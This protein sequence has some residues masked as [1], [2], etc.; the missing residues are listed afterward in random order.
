M[1]AVLETFRS[2]PQVV[3]DVGDGFAGARAAPGTGRVRPRSAVRVRA[4]GRTTAPI[5]AFDPPWRL[6]TTATPGGVLAWFG[7]VRRDGT[8]DAFDPGL[9]RIGVLGP[10]TYDIEI[11][12]ATYQSVELQVSIPAAG[13]PPSVLAVE[14]EAG[15]AYPFRDETPDVGLAPAGQPQGPTLLRGQVLSLDGSALAGVPVTAPNAIA[16]TTDRNGSWVLVFPDDTS[17]GAVTVTAVIAGAAVTAQAEL[18]ARHRTQV[19]QARLKG[20]AV[21][22]SGAPVAGAAV[23]VAGVTGSV[24]S[25]GDGTWSLALPFGTGLQPI[26]VTVAAIFGP[27]TVTQAGIGVVPGGTV[28]VPDHVFPNP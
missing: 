23:S 20:S 27:T 9:D 21:R 14:L 7:R 1:T 8:A 4:L 28:T 10:G 15:P 13:D 11:S 17:S 19:T 6:V 25:T 18:V 5:E 16:A 3:L 22:Q 2:R 26:N 24:T 12:A